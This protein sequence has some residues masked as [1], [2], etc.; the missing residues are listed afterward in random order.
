MTTLGLA[1]TF[2]TSTWAKEAPAFLP[3]ELWPDNNGVHVNAH[4]GGVLYHD[5]TYYWFGEHKIAGPEGNSAQV[6]VSVYSSIDLTHWKNEDIALKV[7]DDPKSDIAM[8]CILERP[9]VIFNAKTG[10]FVMWFHLEPKGQG[11][12]GA[13]SGIAVADR[14]TGPYRYIESLRPNAGVWPLNVPAA[15]QTPLTPAEAAN[16]SKLQLRGGP[17][18]GYPTDL[19]FRR[20]FTGGQMARDMTL[21][22]DDDGA[23]YHVYASEENGTL[24][25]SQLS[26]NFLKPAGKYVRV[27]PG[28]FN[29]APALF[30]HGGKYWL[31]T[32]GC[33][34]WAPNAGRLAVADSIWGPWTALG[35]PWLGPKADTD[36]SFDSQSTFVLPVA[37]KPG[38]F[39]FMADRWRPDN[40]IDG[41]YIWLPVHYRADGGPNVE[42][43]DS[44]DLSVFANTGTQP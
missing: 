23:A 5:G 14:V 2:L 1:L 20:D 8:G 15:L 28:G 35:N 34:G 39:I 7:S 43:R 21:F 33:T 11:Y 22:V 13:R 19:V 9:K 18:P 6:G 12:L 44:W 3:G 27:F 25:I 32:S 17:V 36:L 42:W 31:F 41:R 29:E 37:N 38:S 40:P 24:H 4:G 10:K 30:K 26:D 16:L